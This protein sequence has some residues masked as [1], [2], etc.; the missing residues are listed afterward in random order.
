M[1]SA[2]AGTVALEASIAAL[3]SSLEIRTRERLPLEWAASQ[4]SLALP[5]RRWV[6]LARP[7]RSRLEEALAAYQAAISGARGHP[8]VLQLAM[9]GIERVLMALGERREAP[10]RYLQLG[11]RDDDALEVKIFDRGVD[12]LIQCGD[13]R[14]GLMGQ[15]LRLQVVPND[16]DVVQFG[17]VFRQPDPTVIQCAR[18][19]RAARESLLTCTCSA[20]NCPAKEGQF[21]AHDAVSCLS[22]DAEIYEN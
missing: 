17:R 4:N 7:A 3:R 8:V 12:G 10:S 1:A 20:L 16:L 19:A 18:A 6:A 9:T 15:V 5:W 21:W 11:Q 13:V 2:R 22:L 14:E